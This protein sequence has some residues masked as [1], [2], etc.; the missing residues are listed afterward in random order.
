MDEPAPDVEQSIT[1]N[2]GTEVIIRWRSHTS[3]RR[4]RSEIL[5]V[6]AADDSPLTAAQFDEAIRLVLE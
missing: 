1:L 4:F 3:R 6:T 2:D 5:D